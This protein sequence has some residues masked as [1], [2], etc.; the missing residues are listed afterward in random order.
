MVQGVKV[1]QVEVIRAEGQSSAEARLEK[2]NGSK[3]RGHELLLL[4]LYCEKGKGVL[5]DKRNDSC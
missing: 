3:V 2:Q 4:L 5:I 1:T